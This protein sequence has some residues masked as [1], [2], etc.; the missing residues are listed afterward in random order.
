VEAYL[1][2]DCADLLIFW[3]SLRVDILYSIHRNITTFMKF[4]SNAQD[5]FASKSLSFG[6]GKKGLILVVASVL[7][8]TACNEKSNERPSR[9][10]APP[11]KSAEDQIELER[12]EKE[13]EEQERKARE[14][15]N[16]EKERLERE[17]LEREKE[18]ERRKAES[19][20]E[21]IRLKREEAR[22][23]AVGQVIAKLETLKG[24]V[25]E[26]VTI[27]EVS[28]IGI[29]IRH[30]AGSR[31]VPFEELPLEMQR[32]F[33]F[34]PKEKE[35]ALADEHAVQNAHLA[36]VEAAKVERS[37]VQKTGQAE[38][39]RLKVSKAIATKS[40]RIQVLEDE[41]RSLE[42]DVEREENK[43]YNR[44]QYYRDGRWVYGPGG[45]S[46]APEFRKKLEAKRQEYGVLKQQVATLEVELESMR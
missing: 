37:E 22:R 26:N 10:D 25:Y 5:A 16:A 32:Q 30:D 15:E 33:L 21:E 46:R 12:I 17:R 19:N 13:R 29:A 8:A 38:E 24:D 23:Q 1:T 31:R 14:L 43:K 42:S 27:R 39:Y 45:I 2:T 40:A 4:D 6:V 18:E 20:D 44:P 34:D 41:I 11:A 35:K 36:Q 9:V 7:F 3:K 28:P